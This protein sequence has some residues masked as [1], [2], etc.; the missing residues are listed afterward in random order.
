MTKEQLIKGI[1]VAEAKAWK[2]LSEDRAIL[3]NDHNITIRSRAEWATLYDLRR[4]LG[5]GALS[6]IQLL[7]MDLLPDHV[8]IL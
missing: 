1:Q 5:L 6:N 3:G 8:A 7:E 2:Q 4:S